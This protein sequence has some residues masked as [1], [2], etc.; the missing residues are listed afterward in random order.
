MLRPSGDKPDDHPRCRFPARWS[1]LSE[2]IRPSADAETGAP[3]CAGYQQWTR[4]NSVESISIVYATGY[5]GNPASYYGHTL[6]KFNFAGARSPARLLDVSVNYGAIV[7]AD[8]HPFVYIV[9]SL[10]GGYDGGFSHIQFY[11][12]NHNYGD[13]E[14]RDLW[15]YRLELPRAAV[16]RIVAHA[17]EVLGKR[18][19]YHFFR[20]NCAYRMAELLEVVDGIDI[21]PDR[22]PWV[23]P[24][25]LIRKV[26]N[27][28]HEGKP[29]LAEVIHYPSRQSRFYARHRDLDGEEAALL[30]DL[31]HRRETFQGE[32]MRKRTVASQQA[33]IDTAID[34]YQFIGSPL[35]KAEPALREAHASALSARYQLP[36]GEARAV[37]TAPSPPHTG[38]PPGWSQVS[39]GHERGADALMMLRY[40]PAYYDPLDAD[41][42][43]VGNSTLLMGDTQLL[44]RRD[45]I[46]L[47]RFDLFAVDS[48]NAG[49]TGLPRD[50]A[51][52]MKVRIGVEQ[53][54]LYCDNCLTPRLQ[55][56]IG[57]GTSI[58]RRFFAAANIGGALQRDRA[59]QGGGFARIGLDF[60]VRTDA[61]HGVTLS[62]QWRKPW[63][64]L[65]AYGVTRAEARWRLSPDSDIRLQYDRDET[66]R[67]TAGLG[68][69]W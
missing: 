34:Y 18:Y 3:A 54:R 49:E 38:R 37:M 31:V 24:Q 23:I 22:T 58:T 57:M 44:V 35:D 60:I 56:D 4:G 63:N 64:G 32:R 40:R 53:A 47:A 15:E 27:T 1:W 8:T 6:L 20:L 16:E 61:G 28:R 59:G 12:H 14:L 48:V 13:I 41:A 9:H 5:L 50:R 21:I 25:A 10:T 69:Y 7:A 19:T 52:T 17:W 39:V 36:P 42:G 43:H 29:L 68:F 67:L 51:N 62:Q 65:K 33:I 2:Q 55:G 45:R 46:R 11:F 66:R 26:G 30:A